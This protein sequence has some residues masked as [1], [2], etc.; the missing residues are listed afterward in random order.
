LEKRKT[1]VMGFDALQAEILENRDI[2]KQWSAF[3]GKSQLEAPGSFA[4]ILMQID[5]FL[6]PILSVLKHGDQISLRWNPSGPWCSK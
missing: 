1:E 3:L 4:V 2:E 5:N 6:A